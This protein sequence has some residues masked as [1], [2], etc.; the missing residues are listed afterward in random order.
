MKN[1]YNQVISYTYW[2]DTRSVSFDCQ[3]DRTVDIAIYPDTITY[4][5]N[6]YQIQFWWGENNNHAEPNRGDYDMTWWYDGAST[7]F[8]QRFVLD[9]V[10]INHNEDGDST[11][12]QLIRKY[13]LAYDHTVIYPGWQWS[14]GEGTLALIGL[15]EYGLNGNPLPGYSFT[16]D[17]DETTPGNQG[18]HLT[19]AENGYGGRVEFVFDP[20]PWA[21]NQAPESRRFPE[22]TNLATKCNNSGPGWDSDPGSDVTCIN[23][24][25]DN[26]YD[27]MKVVGTAYEDN[28]FAYDSDNKNLS[29]FQ[30]GA[31]YR[32]EVGVKSDSGG[33]IE[34]GFLDE[35]TNTTYYA[36]ALN[37]TS[38]VQTLTSDAIPFPLTAHPDNIILKLKCSQTCYLN[39]YAA[40]RAPMR[41]RVREKVLYPDASNPNISYPYTYEYEGAS[42]NTKASEGGNSAYLD[43]ANPYTEAYEEFRGHSKVFVSS[44]GGLVTIYKFH[45]DDINN[46]KTEWVETREWDDDGTPYDGP[47]LMNAHTYYETD[48][49]PNGVNPAPRAEPDGT[50]YTD[51][52]I[53][54]TYTAA[55][56]S[57]IYEGTSTCLGRHTIYEYDPDDLYGN[58]TGVREYTGDGNEANWEPYRLTST[59]YA[60]YE[61][62]ASGKYLVSLPAYILQF[63]CDE[64]G[65]CTTLLGSTWFLYDDQT[66]Y[67]D[68]PTT[69]KLTGQRTL[70]CLSESTSAC[71]GSGNWRLF[72]DVA[73]GYDAYGNQTTV[74]TYDQYGYFQQGVDN[75]FGQ[76]NAWATSTCYG[77]GGS[78]CTNDGYHTYPLSNTNPLGHVTSFT[79][80]YQL[81]VPETMDGPNA[82]DTVQ[83]RYDEFGRLKKIWFEGDSEGSPTQQFEYLTN[84]ETHYFYTTATQKIDDDKEISVQKYY[85]G[86]GRLIQTHAL[87]V[88]I[89]DNACTLC[90]LLVFYQYDEAGRPLKQSIPIVFTNAETLTP[91]PGSFT[92]TS[93]TY[94]RLGRPLTVT[95]PD[96]TETAYAYSIEASTLRSV[97]SVTNGNG[98]TTTTKSNILGQV[99]KVQPP[100]GASH[101]SIL[102]AYD[103]LGRLIGVDKGALHTEIRYDM[104]G[105]KTYMDDPDMGVWT[106]DYDALGNLKTQTDAN[107]VEISFTYDAL[108][109]LKTKAYELNG[110]PNIISPGNVAYFYDEGGAGANEIGQRTRMVDATGSTVWDYD[111]RGRVTA[112]TRSMNEALGLGGPYTFSYTYNKANM[113][114]T[115]EYPD[116][117]IV[118]NDYSHNGMPESLC[119]WDNVNEACSSENYV[120][121]TVYDALGRR[122]SQ[123]LG[124]NLTTTY[125]Y[126]E[127]STAAGDNYD[128]R[129]KSIVVGADLL[130]LTY[131]EYDA[132]GNIKE[133]VDTSEGVGDLI[134]YALTYNY[135]ELN[136]L[137]Q[138]TGAGGNLDE[139]ENPLV[140]NY[141]Y[142]Y[143]YNVQG[144]LQTK[145][146]ETLSYN[147]SAHPHA[148]T[149]L[150]A[151]NT[152][153]Y[154]ANGNMTDR[155]ED[156]VAFDQTWTADNKLYQV[157]W[158]DENGTDYLTT[159]LYDGDGNRLLKIEDVTHA[160]ANTEI[161]TLYLGGLY[162]QEFDT[163]TENLSGTWQGAYFPGAGMFLVSEHGATLVSFTPPL[164]NY[165]MARFNQAL[166]EFAKM[167]RSWG[168]QVQAQWRAFW[169]QAFDSADQQH[170]NL[171]EDIE[172]GTLRPDSGQVRNTPWEAA[173]YASIAAQEYE[174]TNT[175]NAYQAPNRAHDVRTRFEKDGSV[176]WTDRTD[177]GLDQT[178][179]LSWTLTGV[180]HESKVR[181]VGEPVQTQMEGNRFA[182][183]YA[184]SSD[185]YAITEWYVNNENGV[186]QGFTL[187]TRPAGDGLLIIGGATNLQVVGEDEAV[188]VA[189]DAVVLTYTGLKAWDSAGKEL[190]ARLEG[191]A[192][193]L[194]I[195]VA[196]ANAVYPITVDP[197]VQSPSWTV[198]GVQAFAQLGYS[199]S[200]AGD[201]NGD[202]YSDVIIG[203]PFYDGGLTD[204]GA[205]FVHYGGPN[206]LNATP[207]WTREGEQAYAYFG[208]S[209]ATAGDVNGDMVSDVLIGADGFD[210]A[211]GLGVPDLGRVFVF[212][213]AG[214][215]SG[216]AGLGNTPAWTIDGT[217][218]GAAFGYT[219]STLGDANGDDCSDVAVGAYLYDKSAAANDTETG[220]VVAYYSQ[221]NTG[222]GLSPTASWTAEGEQG[223]AWFGYALAP[224][225]DVNGDGEA[226]LL[227]GAP[228]FGQ[229][230]EFT[231]GEGWESENDL[232]RVYL[233]H[234]SG[235]GLSATANWTQTGDQANAQF[236][237]AVGAAGDVNGDGFADVVVGAPLYNVTQTLG[238]SDEGKVILYLGGT[239]SVYSS[240]LFEGEQVGAQFG[241]A[242]NTGGDVN[243][244]GYA[245]IL[246]GA[247][248]YNDMYT[249]EGKAFL[250]Y[251]KSASDSPLAADWTAGGGQN[252]AQFGRTVAPAGDVNG[253][254][255]ADIVL[256]MSLYD[257]ISQTDA[258]RTVVYFGGADNLSATP[259][260]TTESD[261]GAAQA[262][263][264][265]STAGDLNGD[266]FADLAIGI[267]YFDGGNTN[268]GRVVVYKGSASGWGSTP[269][270]TLEIDRNNAHFGYTVSSAGDIDGNGYD[271][272]VIGAPN[273][274]TG[275]GRFYVYYWDAEGV[276][277]SVWLEGS[278]AGARFGQAVSTAGDV[279]GDGFGDLLVGAP[280]YD[281]SFSD[282]GKVFLYLGSENG[283]I[284][285]PFWT[286]QGQVPGGM[287]G[288]AVGTAGDVRADGFSDLIIGAWKG[289][290]PGNA[291]ATSTDDNGVAYV[292]YGSASGPGA[293]YA[294]LAEGEDF[295]DYFGKA[296]GTAGDVNG[297]GF[298]DV[299]VGAPNA[300]NGENNEGIAYVYYGSAAGLSP[301]PN[302]TTES[303]QAEAQFGTAVR[304]AGDLNGDGY[305]DLV[306]GAP[307]YN[308]TQTDEG[309]VFVYDGSAQGLGTVPA[310]TITSGQANAKMGYTAGTVG[311]GNGDG[312]A[313]LVAGAPLYESTT[314]TTDEGRAFVY[315]GN[316]HPGLSLN[317]RQTQFDANNTPLASLGLLA[318]DTATQFRLSV[319]GLTPFGCG[320]VRLEWE[321]KPQGT[322]FNGTN[323]QF[324]DWLDTCIPANNTLSEIAN[325]MSEYVTQHWRARVAYYPADFP[326]QQHSR[327]VTNP[328]QGWQEADFRT[329]EKTAPTSAHSLSGTLGQNGWYVTPV[330]IT[331]TATDLMPGSGVDDIEY[332]FAA[333]SEQGSWQTYKEPFTYAEEGTHAF[334]Y[335]AHDKAGNV[336]QQ[337]TLNVVVK[338]DT[339]PPV[340]TANVVGLDAN[341]WSR[342]NPTTIELSAA[343]NIG[344]SNIALIQYRV[345]VDDPEEPWL[346]YN[347]PFPVSGEGHHFIEYQAQDNA[348]NWEMPQTTSFDLD[349]TAPLVLERTP[350]PMVWVNDHTPAIS[351]QL[352]N[353]GSALPLDVAMYL[354]GKVVEVVSS[355]SGFGEPPTFSIDPADV[356]TLAEGMHTVY[357]RAFDVA[358]NYTQTVWQFTVDSHTWV[359]VLAPPDGSVSNRSVVSLTLQTEPGKPMTVTLTDG[360]FSLPQTY[361]TT[362]GV[363]RFPWLLHANPNTIGIT[364]E[365][366]AGNTAETT[367]N[368]TYTPGVHTAWV[369]AATEVFGP[370]PLKNLAAATQP[371]RFALE[372]FASPSGPGWKITDWKIEIYAN[373]GPTQLVRTLTAADVQFMPPATLDGTTWTVYW[374]GRNEQGAWVSQGNHTYQLVVEFT[375]AQG[376]AETITS[377]LGTVFVD[378]EAPGVPTLMSTDHNV[379]GGTVWFSQATAVWGTAS[380]E[381]RS[382][383][384][385][386]TD[387]YGTTPAYVVAE[388]SP[389]APY[390][391][392]AHLPLSEGQVVAV[393]VTAI[394][395]AGNESS[396]AGPLNV[397][398]SANTIFEDPYTEVDPMAIGLDTDVV[399][400]ATTRTSGADI[401]W[402]RAVL[403]VVGPNE[404]PIIELSAGEANGETQPWTG[405]WHTPATGNFQGTAIMLFQALDTAA[406][407]VY[408]EALAAPYLDLIPPWIAIH[409]PTDGYIQAAATLTVTGA[410]EPYS[411]IQVEAVP[412]EGQPTPGGETPAPVL[413]ATTTSDETG[414][415]QATLQIYSGGH[416]TLTAQA[417]DRAGNLGMLVAAEIIVD[418]SGPTIVATGATPAY[419]NPGPTSAVQLFAQIE[420]LTGVYGA[421]GVLYDVPQDGNISP[422]E[423]YTRD[424]E[425]PTLYT[426]MVDVPQATSEGKKEV[427]ITATD[428][429]GNSTI[430]TATAFIVDKTDPRALNLTLDTAPNT[431][432]YVPNNQTV[433]HGPQ[434]G[435]NVLYVTLTVNDENP[436]LDWTAV[437]GVDFVTFPNVFATGDG[438]VVPAN[439]AVFNTLMTFPY[440][441]TGTLDPGGD[442][443]LT[444]TDRAGNVSPRGTDPQAWFTVFWDEVLP[445]LNALSWNLTNALHVYKV[446]NL[447]TLYYGPTASGRFRLQLTTTETGSGMRHVVFPDLFGASELAV[448]SETNTFGRDY[449]NIENNLTT[450]GTFP[451]SGYD[452]VGNMKTKSIS[453]FQDFVG[454]TITLDVEQAGY[455]FNVAWDI[456][457][458][459]TGSGSSG[460]ATYTVEVCV[461]SACQPLVSNPGTSGTHTYNGAADHAYTFRVSAVDHVD[462]ASTQ[463]QTFDTRL[464]TTKY[465]LFGGQRV[466][467]RVGTGPQSAV[468]YMHGDH[469]GSVSM[470]TNTDGTIAS[471]MRFTPFGEELT[472][473]GSEESPTDFGFTSQRNE[474]GFGL[475]DYNARFYSSSLGRFVSPDSIIPG[476]GNP[477]AWDRFSYG[478]N[479]PSRYTDPS[480]HSVDCGPYDPNCRA[481]KIVP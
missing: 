256:G 469:L 15:Q 276:A 253:D 411:V 250:Y 296:V 371:R 107:G 194:R 440:T 287:F 128:G 366:P 42:T 400:T 16:Y 59:G 215:G 266:G 353:S 78:G 82:Y 448:E 230:N 68:H 380:A 21:S 369:A 214:P 262:G 444:A 143:S 334:C 81:G 31:M 352:D 339:L 186:E 306:V 3:G 457:D 445:I 149:A 210:G 162:E 292:Y 208:R 261:Q 278:Q 398:L 77:G 17:D 413:S 280:F 408:E 109:R 391:W 393:R 372:A 32:F 449:R 120:L 347:G 41:Y 267:P 127:F 357:M 311:D 134:P 403:P 87:N 397:G 117:E 46:G 438:A 126:Y 435:G 307:L 326:F 337:P 55:E 131:S 422:A 364:V 433:W 30:P 132:V 384:V 430:F 167:L 480:G 171:Q 295:F 302:W 470:T 43:T 49:A 139:G 308:G 151:D 5:N 96:G 249:D 468:Y 79:Y 175:G 479:N 206:G 460:L 6:R 431:N 9:E 450:H 396:A 452:N 425:D 84:T 359:D 406:P 381:A 10:R 270:W 187:A 148:A 180:G 383:V 410:A 341:G 320:R 368:L 22:N 52:D 346:P 332:M 112:A 462:N 442:P 86:L 71:T 283:L 350:A 361:T 141:D 464:K 101:Y 85:D 257:Y 417:T 427:Q 196:D 100:A 315:Y 277:S 407:P 436:P 358:G 327:W 304:T 62:L 269:A 354:D 405:A 412:F 99:E 220:R 402:V 36:P 152:Y 27:F 236:G 121:S 146:G 401:A 67:S 373:I 456:V 241:Y 202:G 379:A 73:F 466:A 19:A 314:N 198:N 265:V 455:T 135:D 26:D 137:T 459:S 439:G 205:A 458:P 189:D 182:Y 227:V 351:V 161:T 29:N 360:S 281:G 335:R 441:T 50:V 303:G 54:W 119:V 340:T 130:N 195:L 223:G 197:L 235:S 58:L 105:R 325:G 317:P 232:G 34:L 420:D 69:G 477:M 298:A 102:Y 231:G 70:V 275:K 18:M 474:R 237:F 118:F 142:T 93:T 291:E 305:A 297:D 90:D 461:D 224:A 443:V 219:V 242:V 318:F 472:W 65:T 179:E 222:G 251:G 25:G 51:F 288:D 13:V 310:W 207:N 23:E 200:T 221:C 53:T 389:Q 8:F 177:E 14:A 343:D 174:V 293:T 432:L 103:P 163:S 446:P 415:W 95:A 192:E 209:V 421:S 254:G 319:Q 116:G 145:E 394:D 138:A 234:G 239:T 282:G 377:A 387:A 108:N 386:Y 465:Y 388:V 44:P 144:L 114:E 409:Q 75:Q 244:D 203:A 212:Y 74:K 322:L 211:G 199:V 129:L 467:M 416:F 233:F 356:G 476:A 348:G 217:Q 365:D 12:E 48:Y 331:L 309:A 338:I 475:M 376:P 463:E 61:D 170:T 47:L 56:E 473:A 324:G 33:T 111:G 481:G 323:L 385:Y 188:L 2:K 274:S 20:T 164:W 313:D 110:N 225:G 321:V 330:E 35:A 190:D 204:E 7:Q 159:F 216:F 345:D 414:Y 158:V 173:A 185:E 454:P 259:G 418:P 284:P 157:S 272:L 299:V 57:C 94:D 76:G 64:A 426:L 80:N 125:D 88:E 4:P 165:G 437:A 181:M 72:T 336:E 11:Y 133:I 153:F 104:A 434:S 268:E 329:N 183:Q 478:L 271:D 156:G 97:V 279:N 150:G 248:Y 178:W 447:D 399:L 328:W 243:G 349:A 39:K 286:A 66:L 193:G 423:A 124:N 419:L 395:A 252:V 38:D 264:A 428:W 184:V 471:Q 89:V 83:A 375:P 404:A 98:D 160:G 300:E 226:D 176:S 370:L 374:D 172:F 228:R 390:N 260:W 154:D 255:F 294:W 136:R 362:N 169:E 147:D 191:T 40:Y 106:Y 247:P 238:E 258:G 263:F 245:D 229:D 45:Q 140:P 363:L 285:T 213:G 344:G 316:G 92:G 367:L 382:V 240:K 168:Q 312:Y 453:I 246:V 37:M 218:S 113:V 28:I 24:D 342:F 290:N 201:V 355:G 1:I 378:R 392:I 273:Y 289:E 155:T 63:S 429:L 91:P 123:T 115:L 451:I 60:P 424:A 166:Q 122:T 333:C 301:T